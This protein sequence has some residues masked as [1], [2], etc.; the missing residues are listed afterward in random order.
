MFD[1]VRYGHWN[2]INLKFKSGNKYE[3]NQNF[4][5]QKIS[6]KFG[7]YEIKIHDIIRFVV[8]FCDFYRYGFEIDCSKNW[9]NTLISEIQYGIDAFYEAELLPN[10]HYASISMQDDE[11][12]DNISKNKSV[13]MLKN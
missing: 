3:F 8:F 1:N 4:H 10:Y 11:P 2:K 6:K 13:H 5:F 9:L 12:S 7:W